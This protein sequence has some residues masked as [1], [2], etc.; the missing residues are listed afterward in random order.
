[1]RISGI[2]TGVIKQGDDLIEVFVTA[3]NKSLPENSIVIVTSKVVAVAQGRVRHFGGQSEFERIVRA[4]SDAI[5]H[6]S[7]NGGFFLTRKDGLVLPNAGID[8]SNAEEGTCILL[9]TDWQGFVDRF[10]SDLRERFQLA[11]LGVI[12]V[13]SRIISFRSGISGVAM[14]WSGFEGVS[15]ERGKPDIYGKK[16]AVSR[17]AVADD[18]ASVAQ[19]FFGQ[20]AERIPFVLCEDAPVRFT[21]E[22]QDYRSAQIPPAEDL[23]APIF[24]FDER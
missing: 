3:L 8:K 14:A 12:L 22:R 2:T 18:L 4:E 13:D 24:D 15:D 9:P 17:I 7:R 19:I 10:R 5:L 21:D 1:M 11:N 6:D 20:A 16:L 23:Y